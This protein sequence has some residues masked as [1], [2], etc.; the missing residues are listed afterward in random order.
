MSIGSSPDERTNIMQSTLRNGLDNKVSALGKWCDELFPVYTSDG[1]RLMNMD[2]CGV[3][4][5]GIINFGCHLLAFT[6]TEEGFK[7]WVPRRS[8]T[9]MS[10]PGMLD[11]TVGGSLS[12]GEEP[13]D[14]IIREAREE[15]SL[16][17]EET[18]RNIV[19]CGTL[20]YQMAQTDAGMPGCQHQVQYL[21]EI[22]LPPD[23]IPKPC[24]GEAEDFKTMELGEIQ[25]RLKQGEFKLNCAMTWMACLIRHG[26]VN[27]AN[28]P[29]LVEICA[30]LHRKHELFVVE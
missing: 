17:E 14:C 28:E 2:G 1:K 5:F 18:R 27:A 11:N 26:V 16:P 30:R 6:R 13:L 7:W 10:Y 25:T 9:K 21:Y 3:D 8:M 15:A 20:S 22:E 24:D 12:A 29:N 4:A 19:S 23:R